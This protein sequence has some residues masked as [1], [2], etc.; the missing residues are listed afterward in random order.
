MSGPTIKTFGKFSGSARIRLLGPGPDFS[1]SVPKNFERKNF[2]GPKILGRLFLKRKS[3]SDGQSRALFLTHL[4]EGES[5]CES[6][7][8]VCLRVCVCVG[9]CVVRA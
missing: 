2:S 8:S 5:A 1:V 7:A 6:G 4:N 3:G 9:V